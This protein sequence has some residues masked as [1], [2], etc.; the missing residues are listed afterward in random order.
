MDG[1]KLGGRLLICI[2]E[3][4]PALTVGPAHGG[5]GGSSKGGGRLAKYGKLICT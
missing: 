2:I 4:D 3:Y 1:F 5:G